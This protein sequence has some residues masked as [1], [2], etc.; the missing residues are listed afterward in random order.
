MSEKPT[1]VTALISSDIRIELIESDQ[2]WF[3]V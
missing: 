1:D 3:H 2:D